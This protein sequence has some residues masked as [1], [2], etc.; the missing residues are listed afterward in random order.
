MNF[1]A[2]LKYLVDTF[3]YFG[4]FLANLISNASIIFPLPGIIFIFT[5]APVLNPFLVA[6]FGGVGAAIG[7]ITSYLLGRGSKEL[8]KEKY[9]KRFDDFKKHFHKYGGFFWIIGL[10]ATPMPFDIIGIFCGMMEYPPKKYF[11]A[12]LIGEIIKALLVAYASFFSV[13]WLIDIY[14]QRNNSTLI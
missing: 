12:V 14:A 2:F 4:V 7:E 8:L 3:G 11:I 13:T 1:Y 6:I 5:L 10:A 9:H